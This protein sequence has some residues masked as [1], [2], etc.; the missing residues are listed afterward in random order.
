MM[1]ADYDA[2]YGTVFLNSCGFHNIRK[3]TTTRT[4]GMAVQHFLRRVDYCTRR[5]FD[6]AKGRQALV[7]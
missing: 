2:H 5:F 4:L 7:H 1:V 3:L 6:K